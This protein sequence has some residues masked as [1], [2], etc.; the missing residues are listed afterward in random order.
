MLSSLCK[1]LSQIADLLPRVKL[2]VELY[3]TER[4]KLAVANLYASIVKFFIRASDWYKEGKWSHAL[5][6]L[7]RPVELRNKDLIDEIWMHSREVENLAG[8]GAQAEQRDIHLELRELGLKQS[9]TD[10]LLHELKD[11]L[12]GT[13]PFSMIQCLSL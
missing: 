12:I 6:S 11:M 7:T 13:L 1:E 5:H 2:T 10:S 8:T 3:P 9:K 4:I